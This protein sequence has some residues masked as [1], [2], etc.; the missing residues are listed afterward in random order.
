MSCHFSLLIVS[1]EAYDLNFSTNLIFLSLFLFLACPFAGT[2]KKTLPD[3]R[4]QT[5]TPIFSHTTSAVL[6]L[7]LGF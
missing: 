1:F 7:V 2:L 4:S 3:P 6:V 5:L